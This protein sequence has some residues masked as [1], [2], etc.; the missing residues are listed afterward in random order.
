VLE[1]CTFDVELEGS[2]DRRTYWFYAI[3]LASGLQAGDR[4]EL[5]AAAI[6][7]AGPD[8]VAG[9]TS[10]VASG[11]GHVAARAGFPLR[12][13]WDLPAL[14]PGK[15]WAGFVNVGAARDRPGQIGR[16]P[17]R[18]KASTSLARSARLL[19]PRGD[20]VRLRLLPGTAH[21]RI[22]IDL[23]ANSTGLSVDLANAAGVD[24]YVAR[25]GDAGSG[26]TVLDA[27][28]RAA[29]A[30]T[31]LGAAA[32]KH[33]EI[34]AAALQAGR[35]YVTPVN[36]GATDADFTLSVAATA[37]GVAPAL[38]DNAYF[39]PARGGHGV[40]VSRAGDQLAAIWFTYRADGAPT[41]YLAQ[42]TAPGP[43][44]YVWRA[45][46][47]RSTWDGSSNQLVVV[48]EV[49]VTR[50]ADNAFRWSWKV[51]G[52]YGSE[53]FME[54]VAPACVD[55]GTRDYT[56]SWYDPTLPGFGFMVFSVPQVETQIAFLYDGNGDPAWLYGQVSPFG[57]SNIGLLQF[58]G[59]CP[60]CATAA[61]T[62]RPAGNLARNYASQRTGNIDFNGTFLA[63]LSGTWRTNAP[64]ERISLDLS[65]PR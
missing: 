64:I 37:S 38:R 13:A 32:N 28:P 12:L 51:D 46:L 17:V 3:N 7:T 58:S 52:S 49:L 6:P 8:A 44:E 41:W 57:T 40:V 23:P 9:G 15:T 54:I 43:N 1:R 50:T 5:F 65:C 55:G 14:L 39:N 34:G 20:S 26:P 2:N 29:A 63:P 24:L 33:V 25:A 22:A 42:A 47:R 48:G 60:S 31:A 30:G 56:G 4:I 59:F 62:T 45:P 10:L 36:S 19:D 16:I 61:V 11:P 21:E 53:P 18:L 27:P 35:W